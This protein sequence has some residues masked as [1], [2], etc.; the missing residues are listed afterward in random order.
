MGLSFR[1]IKINGQPNTTAYTHAIE[2]RVRQRDRRYRNNR[3]MLI[4]S[5]EIP[6]K[7]S[8]KW[9]VQT[10]PV[11]YRQFSNEDKPKRTECQPTNDYDKERNPK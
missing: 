3:N 2:H 11:E 7:P 10:P 4:A 8:G 6:A 5:N 1:T 9:F